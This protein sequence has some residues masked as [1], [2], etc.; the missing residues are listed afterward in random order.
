MENRKI[1]CVVISSPVVQITTVNSIKTFNHKVL[2][3]KTANLAD[4]ELKFKANLT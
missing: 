2:K 1:L 3:A 4:K